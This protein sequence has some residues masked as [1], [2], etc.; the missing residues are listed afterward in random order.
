MA[1]EHPQEHPQETSQEHLQKVWQS[2]LM[3]RQLNSVGPYVKL[4]FFLLK[5]N[6]LL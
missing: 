4:F 6:F 3:F 1:L 2:L 5:I